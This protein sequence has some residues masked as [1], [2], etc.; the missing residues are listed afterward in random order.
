MKLFLNNKKGFT[1]IELLVVVAIISLLSSIVFASLSSARKKSQDSARV[2]G[3]I[4]VRNALELYYSN[5]G[6]Y[7]CSALGCDSTS[8]YSIN[9]AQCFDGDNSHD[10]V[11]IP[12]LSPT[13]I[14]SLPRD[15]D[16]SKFAGI[17][18]GYWN[19]YA[20]WSNGK[21]YKVLYCN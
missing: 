7:P 4:Q 8:M 16:C 18:N 21:N 3:F 5:N 20:Y 9:S 2:Q 11:Y 15:L 1:L 10:Y 14:P 17:A 6:Q 13:Y 19:G 12:G